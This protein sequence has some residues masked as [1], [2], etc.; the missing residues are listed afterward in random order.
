MIKKKRVFDKIVR[1][2]NFLISI[3]ILMFSVL[4]IIL[5]Y[6]LFLFIV[7]LF[8]STPKPVVIGDYLSATPED[9][10]MIH[11]SLFYP[12]PREVRIF[13]YNSTWYFNFYGFPKEFKVNL[14]EDDD[15]N[16]TRN[17]IE[18]KKNISGE[19]NSTFGWIIL[20][21]N[22]VLCLDSD[23][24]GVSSLAV[25]LIN[26]TSTEYTFKIKEIFP[27]NKE[28]CLIQVFERGLNW[29]VNF[30]HVPPEFKVD[31]VVNNPIFDNCTKNFSI[32]PT[33]GDTLF[34]KNVCEGDLIMYVTERSPAECTFK[35]R[36]DY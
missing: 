31:F 18:E 24:S 12:K 5:A 7:S 35:I 2:E 33:N 15:Y 3:K 28:H 10:I 14:I 11:P 26:Y 22:D 34:L 4:T 36:K 25:S 8:P 21:K 29:Y 9:S 1:N 30:S 20:R 6:V 13:K 32:S 27:T 23:Q 19:Y 17:M 16:L